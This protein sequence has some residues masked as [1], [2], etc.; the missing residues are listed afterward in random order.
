MPNKLSLVSR[1]LPK[2]HP[3]AREALLVSV[4]VSAPR[5]PARCRAAAGLADP[6]LDGRGLAD[7]CFRL[8]P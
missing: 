4:L 1:V 6:R 8:A 2:L 7:A 5:G 3:S